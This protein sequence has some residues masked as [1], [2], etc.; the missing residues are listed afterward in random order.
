[1][2]EAFT[3]LQ[4]WCCQCGCNHN[5]LLYQTFVPSIRKRQLDTGLG[6]SVVWEGTCSSAT[7]NAFAQGVCGGGGLGGLRRV[8]L[9][10]WESTCCFCETE[11]IGFKGFPV[12]SQ[13]ERLCPVCGGGGF[14]LC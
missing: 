5:Q 7:G 3:L 8:F 11:W 4:C 12:A 6:F 14:C 10:G 13:T 2:V 1:M 9:V